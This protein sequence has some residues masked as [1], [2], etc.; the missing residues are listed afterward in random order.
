MRGKTKTREA[1]AGQTDEQ[2]KG[3]EVN[4]LWAKLYPDDEVFVSK[5]SDDLEKIIRRI[6]T[7]C[8]ALG[9]TVAKAK[10]KITSV[11]PKDEGNVP[12][13]AITAK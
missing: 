3:R 11:Q 8:V 6:V 10:T 4:K 5:S 7:A 12:F 2:E 9:L 13:T 1:A